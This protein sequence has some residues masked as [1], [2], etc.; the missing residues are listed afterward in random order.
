MTAS[1]KPV[2][3]VRGAFALVCVRASKL[4]GASPKFSPHYRLTDFPAL[5]ILH[6]PTNN[7]ECVLSA[8]R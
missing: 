3:P 8:D 2:R 7:N 1:V 4:R 5:R 6:V